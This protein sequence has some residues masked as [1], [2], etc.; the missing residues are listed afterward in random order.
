MPRPWEAEGLVTNEDNDEEELFSLSSARSS[1]VLQ[2]QQA[3]D[4]E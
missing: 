1:K 3:M 2:C 4:I